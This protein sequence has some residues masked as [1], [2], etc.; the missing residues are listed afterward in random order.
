MASY[1]YLSRTDDDFRLPREVTS[2]HQVRDTH[3]NFVHISTIESNIIY[4]T[5]VPILY[6][7]IYMHPCMVHILALYKSVSSFPNLDVRCLLLQ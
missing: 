6:V 1:G 3:I 7:F 2:G 5:H 4:Q